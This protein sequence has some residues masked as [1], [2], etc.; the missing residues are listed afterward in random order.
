MILRRVGDLNTASDNV[1]L[2]D[3]RLWNV[4]EVRPIEGTAYVEV[5]L[6]RT[7]GDE[8]VLCL[9]PDDLILLAI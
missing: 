4:Y 8:L 2:E 7:V 5:H 3:G 9:R 1:R 6:R